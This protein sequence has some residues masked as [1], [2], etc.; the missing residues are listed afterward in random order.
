MKDHKYNESEWEILL[1]DA[2][3]KT[4]ASTFLIQFKQFLNEWKIFCKKY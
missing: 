1:N 4:Q 3:I 2:G